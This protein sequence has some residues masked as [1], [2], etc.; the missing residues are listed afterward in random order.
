MFVSKAAQYYCIVSLS[1]LYTVCIAVLIRPATKRFMSG[2]GQSIRNSLIKSWL[3][4]H[5]RSHTLKLTLRLRASLMIFM[6]DGT[7]FRSLALMT[8]VRKNVVRNL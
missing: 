3:M 7:V 6:K 4:K 1:N 8:V 2:M 5:S